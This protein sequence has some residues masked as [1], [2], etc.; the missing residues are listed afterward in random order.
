MSARIRGQE[1]ALT[2]LVDG[3]SQ[4]GSFAK[5]TDFKARP[6]QE[7]TEDDFL[8]EL[9]SDLDFQHHGWDGSFTVQ[10]EDAAT[11]E[12]L[13]TIVGNEEQH[14]PHPNITITALYTFREP[15]NAARAAVFHDVFIKENEESYK[16]KERVSVDYEFKCKKRSLIAAA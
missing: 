2:I 9:E 4:K 16:R 8:G 13:D 10:V 12:L 7:I 14:L 11:L 3:Q 15:G 1:V 6:R 5:V